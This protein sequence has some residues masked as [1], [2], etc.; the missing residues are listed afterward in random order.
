[1][2]CSTN[3]NR[4]DVLRR[5]S[6]AMAS[7]GRAR[8]EQLQPNSTREAHGETWTRSRTWEYT[9]VTGDGGQIRRMHRPLGGGDASQDFHSYSFGDSILEPRAREPAAEEGSYSVLP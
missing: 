9:C 7:A 6:G 1:M 2:T 3:N 5:E 4:N 8:E